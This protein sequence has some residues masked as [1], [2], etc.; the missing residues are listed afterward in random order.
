[1]NHDRTCHGDTQHTE[2]FG[3]CLKKNA[4]LEILSPEIKN[5][6]L[7]PFV[8]MKLYLPEVESKNVEI[9]IIQLINISVFRFVTFCI[10]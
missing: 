3:I 6:P 9:D 7:A 8:T 5:V 10:I 4:V 1:M 2:D